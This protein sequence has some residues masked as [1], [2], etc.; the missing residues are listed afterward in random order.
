MTLEDIGGG[1]SA[2]LC[3]TDLTACCRRPY[4]DGRNRTALGNWFFPN[5]SRVLSS[6]NQQD[7]HRTRGQMRLSLNRRRGGDEGVYRCVVSDAMNVTQTVYIGLYSANTSAGE[8]YT[9]Y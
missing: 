2:L 7:F 9:Y 3:L 1:D 6:G 8:W 4:T 5:G